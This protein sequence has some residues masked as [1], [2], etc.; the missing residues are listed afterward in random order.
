MDCPRTTKTEHWT[1]R[2]PR[3]TN[4]SGRYRKADDVP[5][6]EV[7]GPPHQDA[8][9]PWLPEVGVLERSC[10]VW[11]KWEGLYIVIRVAL[12]RAFKSGLVLVF[13]RSLPGQLWAIGWCWLL[14]RVVTDMLALCYR[15]IRVLLGPFKKNLN[16]WNLRK[17]CG[18]C[19]LFF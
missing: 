15:G 9:I 10:D 5:G 14:F 2:F 11:M 19:N 18:F 1:R 8:R 12:L 4:P 13:S 7:E 6:L 16:L 17:V 3:R